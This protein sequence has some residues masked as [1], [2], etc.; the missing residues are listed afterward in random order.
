MSTHAQPVGGNL[1]TRSYNVLL[2]LVGL[3]GVI[4]AWRAVAGLGATTALSDG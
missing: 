1:R 3:M 2:A 4:V